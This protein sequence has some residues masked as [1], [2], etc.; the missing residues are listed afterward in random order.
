MSFVARLDSVTKSFKKSGKVIDG[1]TL[2]IQQ[3]EFIS[4]LGPSGSGKTTLLRIL[5]NLECADSGE[6]RFLEARMPG[7]AAFVF[8]EAAL[9]PWLTVEQ[10]VRLP[11]ELLARRVDAS[12]IESLLE[13][14][15]LGS[16]RTFLPRELSGGMKMRASLARAL[17]THPRYLFL[18]EPFAALDEVNRME[19][20]E[21]LSAICQQFSMTALLVTHSITEAVFLSDRIH[22]LSNRTHTLQ[23]TMTVAWPKPRMDEFRVAPDFSRLVSLV[24]DQFVKLGGE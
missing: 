7:D 2:D 22:L 21:E 14:V 17:V 8:Q 16:A 11:C 24:R 13:L 4:L 10:N 18:D 12:E 6:V 19:L 20:E 15:K 9:L 5:S 3:G 23:T 1:V